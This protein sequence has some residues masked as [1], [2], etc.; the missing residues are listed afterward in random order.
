MCDTLSHGTCVTK[1]GSYKMC[2]K[3]AICLMS[4]DVGF[5]TSTKFTYLK[6]LYVCSEIQ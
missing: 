4:Y 1:H 6:N 3:S 5:V 2:T